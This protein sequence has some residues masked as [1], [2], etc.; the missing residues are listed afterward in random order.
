MLWQPDAGYRAGVDAVFLAAACPAQ[1]GESV[2]ELGCGIGAAIFCLGA[3]VPELS[4]TAVER[5][6]S[7]VELAR[8]NAA[9]LD[10]KASI[11][12]ADLTDLPPELRAQSFHHVIANP[13]YFDRAESL[14]SP[15]P[16]REAAMGAKTPLSAWVSV[17]AKRLRPKGWLTIIHRPERLGDLLGAI[18]GAGLG[19]VQVQ[20]L[21]PRAARDANLLLVRARKDG[22]APLRLHAPIRIHAREVHESDG[23]DYTAEIRGVLREGAAMPGFGA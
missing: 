15:E 11:F 2:L 20:P 8:R 4:L 14:S 10:L 3:R 19:S 17:A 13:P 12:Q 23:E 1:P 6:A 18:M 21:Q 5:Q 16:S 9:D 7:M 22:R